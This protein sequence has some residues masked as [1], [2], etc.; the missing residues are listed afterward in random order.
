VEQL[1]LL[2]P[3]QPKGQAAVWNTLDDQQKAVVVA[4][5]MR[6]IVRVAIGAHAEQE[7]QH[8]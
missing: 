6:L 4:T 2:E 5:L 3:P 7:P 1:S 8:E